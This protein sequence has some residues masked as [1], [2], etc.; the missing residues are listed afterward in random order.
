M[1]SGILL[2]GKRFGSLTVGRELRCDVYLCECK[3]G[4]NIEVFRSQLTKGSILHCG[5]L[6]KRK[7]FYKKGHAFGHVR[8][9]KGR[10][11]RLHQRASSEYLSYLAMRNRCLYKSTIGYPEYG[12]RGIQICARWQE[13]RGRGFKNFLE[14]LGPRPVGKTLD[15]KDVQGHYTPENCEWNDLSTQSHNQRRWLFPDGVGE[16]PV[17]PI[18]QEEEALAGG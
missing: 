18:E 3:C 9:Y 10:D 6:H 5:C 11:G 17:V 16:P 7:A 13:S 1:P 14:D 8:C 15:R 4:T 2:T 12:G